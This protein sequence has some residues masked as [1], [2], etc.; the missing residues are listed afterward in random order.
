MA[1]AFID[2]VFASIQGEGPLVGQR[3]IF[4]RFIGCDL[5]CG[6]CD[7]PEAVKIS[8]GGETR[9]CRAQ[10]SS[11]SFNRQQ[12][13]NPVSAAD[14]TALCI[15]LRIAGPARPVASLTGGEPLLHLGFLQSWLPD[16]RGAF[17]IF[18]E[19]NGIHH[20]ALQSMMRLIDFISMDIKLPSSTGQ[21]AYWNEH[22]RFLAAASELRCSVKAV[23]TKDTL[24]EDL[25][26]AARLVADVGRSIP[27]VI[28]PASVP[29]TPPTQQLFRLQN[30][31]L[32]ILEDVRIIPQVQ[33]M[34]QVP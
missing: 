15:R 24:E 1:T 16:I 17:D 30:T 25:V 3:H 11:D 20:E 13:R 2:E 6:Y 4:I 27:F 10:I 12:L 5:R 32:G 14:L 7:T 8:D 9:S 22:R 26:T 23:V 33:R 28:Q 21:R 31:A 34:L 18:L 19:T 29:L